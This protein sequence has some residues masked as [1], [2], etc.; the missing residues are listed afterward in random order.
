MSGELTPDATGLYERVSDYY[1]HPA[2]TRQAGGWSLWMSAD[3]IDALISPEI[4]TVPDEPDPYWA[5]VPAGGS[6][7]GIY[8]HQNDAL[9]HATV[10]NV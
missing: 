1:G 8:D 10:A 2:Y 4:G 5:R 6:F 3:G 7:P 9:G